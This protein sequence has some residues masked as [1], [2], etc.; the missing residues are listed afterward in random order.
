MSLPARL[1]GLPALFAVLESC[2]SSSLVAMAMASRKRSNKLLVD[3]DCSISPSSSSFDTLSFASF[4]S[5]GVASEGR[6][7][8]TA[9]TSGKTPANKSPG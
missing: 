2:C 9:K 6:I 1:I 4:D 3:V 5:V 8:S 7:A